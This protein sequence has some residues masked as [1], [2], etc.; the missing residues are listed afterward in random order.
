MRLRRFDDAGALLTAAAPLLHRTEA[1]NALLYGILEQLRAAPSLYREP[2]LALLRDEDEA[3]RAVALRTPPFV[4]VMTAF[5]DAGL[6]LLVADLRRAGQ[7]PPGVVGPDPSVTRFASAWARAT[8]QTA[9]PRMSQRSY[10]L[11]RV[12]RPDVPGRLRGCAP[13]D[14][15]R[16][17]AWLRGFASELSL[18]GADD[19]V[20]VARR[21]YERGSLFF[22]EH[23]GAP[24]AMAGLAAE[25]PRGAR[26]GYVYTPPERRRRGYAAACTAA[27]SQRYLDAGKRFCTLNADLDNPVSNGVYLRV[28]YR[29]LVDLRE[30]GFE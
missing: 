7:R 3:P 12:A 20:P 28:G 14:R 6:P 11:E 13:P 23:E 2:Y 29:P 26:I 17:E 8:D 19:L 24:C 1:D 16:V 25:T 21:A 18:L 10:C 9:L 5:P 27:V 15:E 30:I 4:M 22:W